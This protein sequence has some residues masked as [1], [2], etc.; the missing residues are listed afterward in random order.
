MWRMLLPA[1]LVAGCAQLPPSPE[2][3]QARRFE[4]VPGKSV[5]YVARQLVDSDAGRSL[6]LDERASITTWRG[7]Y[8]RW[9]VEPGTHRITGFG[10]G[11]ENVTL[12]TAPGQLYYLQHTVLTRGSDS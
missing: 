7:T 1:L 10:G 12:T 6:L 9:E 5:I 2:D 3:I 4:A 11:G 8:Y